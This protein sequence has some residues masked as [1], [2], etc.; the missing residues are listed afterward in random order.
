MIQHRD[1]PPQDSLWSGDSSLAVKY[2]E[3]KSQVMH[4][5]QNYKPKGESKF[6]LFFR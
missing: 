2:S 4:T 3:H 6:Y 1:E 5:A